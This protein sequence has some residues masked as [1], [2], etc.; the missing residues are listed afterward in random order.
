MSKLYKILYSVT[1]FDLFLKIFEIF[2]LI[3]TGWQE[4][5]VGAP[6]IF[7][8]I[9]TLMSTLCR[10]YVHPFHNGNGYGEMEKDEIGLRPLF[11]YQMKVLAKRTV[12]FSFSDIAEQLE[13]R[14][15]NG[16]ACKN[17][18]LGVRIICMDLNWNHFITKHTSLS[19]N[20][21]RKRSWGGGHQ[22]LF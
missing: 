18:V 16:V 20:E 19:L 7:F 3:V 17:C 12:S 4:G 13:A 14:I 6:A 8:L 9:L 22:N 2:W 21:W 11:W 10:P 5:L 15:E 1:C